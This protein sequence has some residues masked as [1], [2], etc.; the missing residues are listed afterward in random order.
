MA[1]PFFCGEGGGMGLG[2]AVREMW[3]RVTGVDAAASEGAR[4]TASAP[5]RRIAVS[6]AVH[7]KERNGGASGGGSH[8]GD[9]C[10]GLRKLPVARRAINVIKD[11]I[12]CM[13]WR[14]ELRQDA[15]GSAE[16]CR[17]GR[18]QLRCGARSAEC[19]ATAFGR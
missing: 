19:D 4:K 17:C 11:R 13:D 6:D 14:I 10:G 12:A 18:R 3:Q 16:S 8:S 9:V 15:A 5:L 1:A 2:L 7:R